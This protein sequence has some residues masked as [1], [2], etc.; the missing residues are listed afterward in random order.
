MSVAGPLITTKF[1]VPTRR[2]ATVPRPRLTDR[3]SAHAR[4]LL[5][6]APAGFGKTS[7]VSEWLA[8]LDDGTRVAWLSLDERDNDGDLFWS[9]LITALDRAV[10]G[11]GT[12]AL[13]LLGSNPASLEAVLATLV[14]DLD[15][16]ATP[17]V[18]VLDDFHAIDSATVQA[19]MAFL[20]DNMPS[21][22][23]LV[24]ASRAD[25]ALPL[26][27]LRSRGELV[28]LRASDLR[29]TPAEASAY[30]NDVMG[31]EIR[32]DDVVALGDRTEGWIAAIQL[33]ALSMQGRDDSGAFIAGFAG[34]DRYVVDYLVEEVLQRQPEAVRTFLLETSILSRLTGDLC[35]AVTGSS[36]GAGTLEAL[37]RANLFLVPL[38]DH[39]EWY[40]YHHLFAEMLRARLLDELSDRVDELH[41]RASAWF[42][43][44]GHTTEAISHAIDASAFDRAA[45]L[46]AAAMPGMQQQRQENTLVGWFEQLP[47]ET[48]RSHPGLSLGFAG[49]LLSSGRTE[50][51]E[52]LLRDAEAAAGGESEG[53]RALRS[54]IA[55]YRAAQALTRGDLETASEQSAEA[56]ELAEHGGD[57]DRGSSTG[58]RGLVL[59]AR[60]DLAAAQESWTIS[61][62][63]LYR[64]GHRSDMLGGSIAMADIQLARGRPTEAHETYRRGLEVAA[65]AD[66]PLRG[67]A[68]M[69]VGMCDLLR[70]RGDLEGAH[71]Q[72]AA[73]EA[74]GEYAGLPQNRHRRRIAA[75]RLVRAEGDPAAAIPLLDEAERLY[76]PDFF[77][78]VRPIPALRA[79]AQLAA[80]RTADALAWAQRSGV[81]IDDDL[82]YLREFDHV[83]LVRVLLAGGAG[84]SLA[85]AGR[86]LERLLHAAEEGGRGG[87]VLELLVLRSLA[88][89]RTGDPDT[90]LDTLRRAVELAEPEGYLRTF[91]D[92][93]EP[94][95]RLLGALAKRGAESAYLRR[96]HAAASGDRRPRSTAQ[97]LIEP[98]S[99]R[100]LDV[101][102]LLGSELAGPEISR[103][104]MV[105][106]NTLRTHTKNVYA[107]LGVTSRRE[108]VRRADE[109]GLLTRQ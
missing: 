75:A 33:A 54:G 2:P 25:P 16:A 61:L 86:L 64:A 80:G 14:N 66:P 99:D 19:G 85:D 81:T 103:E 83:T 100:E 7:I 51:V 24:I 52:P 84:K 47:A 59:W 40:R 101:L 98:L 104:L 90:S 57:I 43:Q 60:G 74:L 79:R 67:A 55:L 78:E 17:V 50:G 26:A 10:P 36:G 31:L 32:D 21:S 105:S 41:L 82:S 44:R 11:A 58:L 88:L 20:V 92:E 71:R 46:I 102:R 73:A 77:P 97:G 30:L 72:L 109:L 62:E 1:N 48:V 70:E 63:S 18:L 89:H 37:D 96:L 95:A 8:S 68:D 93:G 91:A 69:H 87:S 9:Y 94:M 76:T 39:R 12:A 13:D 108:A 49:V 22:V 4:L 38:D 6:A 5:V 29:F 28:E 27:R 53:T 56:V 106:L 107:K 65:T 3:L 45:D 34:D 23:R 15:A 35:D 42:E